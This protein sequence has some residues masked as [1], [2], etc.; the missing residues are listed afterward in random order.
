VEGIDTSEL[1]ISQEDIAE[2][3]QVDTEEW[4]A[5]LPQFHE[6]YAKFENLPSE[7][8]DQLQALEQR[9]S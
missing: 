4:K 8:R 6:H 9:L 1:D 5:Q 7:L 3:L 2:L